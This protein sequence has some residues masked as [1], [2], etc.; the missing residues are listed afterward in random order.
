MVHE[1]SFY[2][3]TSVVTSLFPCNFLRLWIFTSTLLLEPYLS[4]P[5]L[6]PLHCHSTSLSLIRSFVMLSLISSLP[7]SS[8]HITLLLIV[9]PPYKKNH[10]FSI[11]NQE[12]YFTHFPL[13]LSYS[14]PHELSTPSFNVFCLLSSLPLWSYLDVVICV[15]LKPPF[16]PLISRVVFYLPRPQLYS[17]IYHM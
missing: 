9:Y 10:P 6:F 12:L 5:W 14:L 4:Y 8:L 3:C 1:R 15:P 16:S 11:S 7:L 17:L 2:F 13:Y